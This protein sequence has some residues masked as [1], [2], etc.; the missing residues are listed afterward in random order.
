MS[1]ASKGSVSRLYGMI[2]NLPNSYTY[3]KKMT[4]I[5]AF[6]LLRRPEKA[7]NDKNGVLA[8]KAGQGEV[9]YNKTIRTKETARSGMAD[10]NNDD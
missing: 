8:G 10:A 4:A 6:A 3:V 7:R 5:V 9:R 2:G 1:A